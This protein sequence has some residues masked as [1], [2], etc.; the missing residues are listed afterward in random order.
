[1]KEVDA[2]EE[3]EGE[4]EEK[5][6]GGCWDFCNTSHTKCRREAPVLQTSGRDTTV[7]KRC[8]ISA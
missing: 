5:E 3:V 1:M 8:C 2:E 6:E 4:K 7:T